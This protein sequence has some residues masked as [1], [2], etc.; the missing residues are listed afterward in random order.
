M[1]APVWIDRLIDAIEA[2]TAAIRDEAV[3]APVH[4]ALDSVGDG[5]PEP[6]FGPLARYR[7]SEGAAARIRDA[8]VRLGVDQ[9]LFV[10]RARHLGVH[11]SSAVQSNIER[12]QR[13]ATAADMDAL[14][15]ALGV[16]FTLA[17]GEW[18]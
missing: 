4:V 16:A 9:R 3:G 11:W 6:R 12:A 5:P 18:L 10:R 7:I 8:R 14:T 15:A 17:G 2:L 1:A 13:R